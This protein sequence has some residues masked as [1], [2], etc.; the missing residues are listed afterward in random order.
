MIICSHMHIGTYRHTRTRRHRHTHVCAC[1]HTHTHAYTLSLSLTLPLRHSLTHVHT[2]FVIHRFIC[3]PTSTRLPR[4]R[5]GGGE[6]H[7]PTIV[8]GPPASSPVPRP[9]RPLDPTR[10]LA[11]RLPPLEK[12]LHTP[13]SPVLTSQR[14]RRK[15]A[16]RGRVVGQRSFRQ[17]SAVRKSRHGGGFDRLNWLAQLLFILSSWMV[18]WC[19]R[20]VIIWVDGLN[21]VINLSWLDS[22]LCLLIYLILLSIW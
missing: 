10:W 15:A 19:I 2:L 7:V 11:I 13:P 8:T 21:I 22:V 5:N 18:C 16:Q 9:P 17:P 20:H 4:V 14:Y 6:T 12:V 3:S 1:T